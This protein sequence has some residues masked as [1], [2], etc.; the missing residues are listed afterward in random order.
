MSSVANS[1]TRLSQLEQKLIQSIRKSIGYTRRST[2]RLLVV[3]SDGLTMQALVVD[4]QAGKLVIE[5]VL[6]SR[7]LEPRAVVADLLLQLAER[8]VAVPSQAIVVSTQII[9]ALV[10]L[11]LEGGGVLPEPKMLELVRWE[12]EALLTEHSCQWPLGWLLIG[13]GYLSA[14]QREQALSSLRAEQA[15]AKS[16][17]GRSP[18][19]FGEVVL[20]NGWIDREQLEECLALQERLLLLDSSIDCSW[21]P[22]PVALEHHPKA[23]LCAAMNSTLRQDWMQAFA[24]HNIRL[25][26]LYPAAGTVAAGLP[27]I[28]VAQAI[29]D[30]QPSVVSCMRVE[31]GQVV[32]YAMRNSCEQTLEV[33]VLLD[34]CKPIL[35]NDVTELYIAGCHAQRD[36][37]KQ[38]LSDHLS[39]ECID[40]QVNLATQV[41]IVAAIEPPAVLDAAG[42]MVTSCL[43][44]YSL[45]NAAS[46]IQ[47]QG[48]PPPP[49][50]YRQPRIQLVAAL[51]LLLLV[52][53]SNEAWFAWQK[54][55]LQARIA[56]NERKATVILAANEKLGKQDAEHKKVQAQLQQWMTTYADFRARKQA[57]ESVLIRRQ[58]FVEAL[59]P[60]LGR[61]I[62]NRVMIDSFE[63]LDWYKFELRGW[64]LDQ[65][66][67][68]SFNE[69]LTQA[70]ESWGLYIADSPSEVN[71]HNGVEGYRFTFTLEHRVDFPQDKRG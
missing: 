48:E 7:A 64:G 11:P 60:A 23:W 44:F 28:E 16:R 27:Q 46:A 13:R 51:A 17:G 65:Q 33:A 4:L 30:I 67:I 54:R 55:H 15:L 5:Q 70:L 35:R 20:Q 42:S 58:Q 1:K 29:V 19:R 69:R 25:Q 36:M 2:Q 12:M 71:R 21:L 39:V 18:A 40:L 38:Q 52:V 61:I 6:A 32:S 26:W 45:A 22:Q 57:I 24:W 56:D 9:P 53:T 37:Y 31:A 34:L 50:L 68:D 66:A 62:P 49:P 63:E 14:E 43:H 41:N 47:L 10:E 8:E 59:L 3:Q